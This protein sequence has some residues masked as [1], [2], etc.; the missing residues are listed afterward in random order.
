MRGSLVSREVIADSIE[1]V[2]FT[3]GFDAF[4]G[5]GA[6]DKNLPGILMAAARLNLPSVVV[7]GGSILPG[8]HRG[9]D[10][11][12]QSVFEAVGRYNKNEMDADELKELE[13]AACPVSGACGG[14]FT[15]NTMA[16]VVEAIG[17]G[18]PKTA[19]IPNVDER[20]IPTSEMAG[21]AIMPLI[22]KGITARQIMTKK[23]FENAI[24]AA[25]AVGGSTN[26]VLHLLAV[27]RE[28]EVDLSIDDFDRIGRKV[29]HIANLAPSGTYLMA[30]LDR[31]GGVSAVLKLLLDAGL[32]HG[33]VL[34]VTGK[35]MAENLKDV[36]VQLDGQDVL[37]P[38]ENPIHTGGSLVI[39]KGNLAPEGAVM[40]I[41]SK[42]KRVFH[43]GPARVF[44]CEEEAFKAIE[45]HRIQKGD[46]IVIRNEGPKGGP[47]M[48][49]MLAVTSALVGEYGDDVAL[50][51]DGRFSGA[52]RGPMIGHVSPESAVGGPIALIEEGDLITI[53]AENR[54]LEAAVENSEWENRRK[55]W[56]PR[57]SPYTKGVLGKYARSVSSASDGAITTQ[58]GQK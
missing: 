46:V 27:A 32:L 29:P 50:L 21:E 49:E 9:K 55:R 7:Y 18:I 40:K 41:T 54:L 42:G 6:C 24:T 34:T 45:E 1:L 2:C 12:I 20:K 10:V 52:T 8:N 56:H 25:L 3:E 31:V 17:M 4:V 43:R 16:T 33:D 35:T 5:V 48:R 14:M 15:A 57:T 23:A 19:A 44:E 22:E 36:E 26:V 47:G 13:C 11:N 58:T 38:V 37:Y 53:D 51:T 30:D 39:L 28:A